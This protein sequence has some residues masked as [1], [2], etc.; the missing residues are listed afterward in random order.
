LEQRL[1]EIVDQVTDRTVQDYYREAFRELVFQNFKRRPAQPGADRDARYPARRPPPGGKFRDFKPRPGTQEAISPAVQASALVRSGQAGARHA[2]EME[3]G[4]LL[5][6]CPEIALSEGETLAILE[7]QDP[8]LDRLRH[9]LLNLAAS[10]SSLEKAGVQTHFMRKGM[11]DLLARF[12]GPAVEEEDPRTLFQRVIS[13]LRKQAGTRADPQ[14]LR[15]AMN[16][17]AEST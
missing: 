17:G 7:L 5:V 16:R 14:R 15:D 12:A 1:K 4:R 8:S 13:Q 9:E 10:G 6:E 3:L 11:A 2:R